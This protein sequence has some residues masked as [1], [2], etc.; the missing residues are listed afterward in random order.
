MRLGADRYPAKLPDYL[1]TLGG[2][3]LRAGR[4]DEA[5]ARLNESLKVRT[6]GE[7]AGTWLFLALAHARRGDREQARRLY[8]QAG[9]WVEQRRSWFANR[10]RT[11]DELYRL[12]AEVA[13]LIGS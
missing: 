5:I 11:E 4:Y 13:E 2:A 7:T 8:D 10:W 3:L 12:R 9:A 6:N 1:D